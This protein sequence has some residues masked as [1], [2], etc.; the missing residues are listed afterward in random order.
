MSMALSG[1]R[2]GTEAKCGW[3]A[4]P[5][6]MN[7]RTM[8]SAPRIM[9]TTATGSSRMRPL[10]L[11]PRPSTT[12]IVG[13]T[14]RSIWQVT[15]RAPTARKYWCKGFTQKD[16]HMLQAKRVGPP[17]VEPVTLGNR[18]YEVVHWGRKRGLGQ[19]G[20]YNVGLKRKS[21]ARPWIPQIYGNQYQG[22][23]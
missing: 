15:Y 22:K 7:S 3:G 12:R 8:R 23:P 4:K 16:S 17:K 6:F 9:P 18:R 5:L 2:R 19:N 11:I 14:L 10:F 21:R 13:D 20:G 1:A